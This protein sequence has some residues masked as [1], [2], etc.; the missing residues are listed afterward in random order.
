[1]PILDLYSYRKKD[2]E[3]ETPD[4]F[5]YDELP[6]PLRVQIIHIWRDA[7]GEYYVYSPHAHHL[8]TK[9]KENNKAW[10]CI[11]KAFAKEQGVFNLGE[12]RDVASRCAKY[13]LNCSSIEIALDL[14]EL[15]FRYIQKIAREFS[16]FDRASLGI[17]ITATDAITELNERFRRAGVGYGF[18]DGK[19]FRIDSE[20][21]H[22]E[23]VKPALR[24]LQ[25]PGFEGPCE[26]F[27]S[28]YTHYRIGQSKD[29]ITDAN[30]AFESTLKAIC[31]QRR[32]E[33]SQGS[34]SSDLLKVVKNSG[35][36]PDYLDN[37]FDQ[38]VATLNSGLPKV[39]NKESAH[40]QGAVPRETPDY[41]AAYALHLSAAKIL[42]LIE[43]H[44]AKD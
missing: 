36:L 7:I 20:L 13:F 15:T 12:E 34:R 29:A 9:K 18:E 41:V 22:A 44:K 5:T 14:V 1:M 43:S 31:D 6:E 23:I 39:R 17:Q 33:F 37:S 42:F 2:A 19:I 24:F 28:A 38:L 11:H 40:G 3:G 16:D 27:M 35:L 10:E 26:E 8:Q 30:N 4:V 21:I 32:W 25:T